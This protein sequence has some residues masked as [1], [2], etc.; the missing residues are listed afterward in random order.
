MGQ[1][2]EAGLWRVCY[3][4]SL[5]R[6]VFRHGSSKLEVFVPKKCMKRFQLRAFPALIEMEKVL[7]GNDNLDISIPNGNVF[8]I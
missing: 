3:Q 4:Q 1:S 2:G 5:P 8:N 6:L 7:M